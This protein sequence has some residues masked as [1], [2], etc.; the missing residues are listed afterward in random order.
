MIN[1]TPKDIKIF[2][3]AKLKELCTQ[4]EGLKPK[5]TLGY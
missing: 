3:N 1:L 4:I 5:L 2:P